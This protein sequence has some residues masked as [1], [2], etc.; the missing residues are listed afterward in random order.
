MNK[1]MELKPTR[2][3][4]GNYLLHQVFETGLKLKLGE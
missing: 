1:G 2:E 4:A 3:E